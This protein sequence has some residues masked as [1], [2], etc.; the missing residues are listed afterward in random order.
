MK[1]DPAYAKKVG[2]N[3]AQGPIIKWPE[4]NSSQFQ[5]ADNDDDLYD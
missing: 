3:Q 5:N 1:M 2:G 4:D